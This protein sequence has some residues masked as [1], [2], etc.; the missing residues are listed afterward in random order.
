VISD[1]NKNLMLSIKSFSGA[2]PP[3]SISVGELDLATCR[4]SSVDRNDVS[5]D[6]CL[7]DC[8]TKSLTVKDHVEC[9]G[10]DNS[11]NLCGELLALAV[12]DRL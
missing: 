9:R 11:T 8:G 1:K 4:H 12:D 6:V 7:S 10:R 5:E 2:I 3:V